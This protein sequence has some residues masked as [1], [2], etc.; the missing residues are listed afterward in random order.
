MPGFVDNPYKYMAHAAVFA[1]SSRWEGLPTV[2]IEAM[3]CGTPVVST[4][5]PSGPSEI[6]ESGRWGNLAPMGGV[7]GMATALERALCDPPKPEELK[8]RAAEFSADAI[9]PQYL[10]V[11]KVLE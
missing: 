3:A 6:L 1:L 10:S 7:D 9:V 2:L 4:D 8:G 5:C 11:L